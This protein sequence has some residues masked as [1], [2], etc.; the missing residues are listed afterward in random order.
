MYPLEQAGAA[1]PVARPYCG[2]RATRGAV[3]ARGALTRG[4]PSV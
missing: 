2:P 4:A 3:G 1:P